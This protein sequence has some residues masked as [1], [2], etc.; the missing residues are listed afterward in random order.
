ETTG[1][2]DITAF[3]G[4]TWVYYIGSGG[5]NK[6]L[7]YANVT[8]NHHWTFC[9]EPGNHTISS[10]LSLSYNN[11]QSQQRVFIPTLLTLSNIT[12]T[13]KLFLLP[14]ALGLFTQFKTEDTIGN[15]LTLVKAV[16]TRVLG[17]NTITITSSFTDGSGLVV[18]FL[19]PDIT[20]SGS[21][22]KTGFVTN[23]FVFVPITDIRVVVLGITGAVI[24][25]TD[26]SQN[27]SYQTFPL[28]SSL[29]NNTDFLFGFDVNASETLTLI[30]MNITSPNGT[31]LGFQSNAGAGF[32]SE[33]IN[34]KNFTIIN[35]AFVIQTS[36][37]TIKFV[38]IWIVGNDFIGDYSL[39]RQLGLFLDYEFKDFTRLLIVIAVI[40]GLMI[41]LTAGQIT[42]TSESQIAVLI[43]LVWIFSVVGWLQN[44]I[45]V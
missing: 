20:Y 11:A 15:T 1:E 42:D 19:N 21:F 22:S 32:I 24:G 8:E 14:T 39:F 17:G 33:T 6:T 31:Q 29:Q 10:T 2:E 12:T 9:F 44:P 7:N 38:R 36:N 4:S 43:I 13:Q 5:V 34:T 37:E 27:M 45:V 16:I 28:N 23:N 25:G 3:I 30:S 35:G 41:F 18:F 40:F 26:I